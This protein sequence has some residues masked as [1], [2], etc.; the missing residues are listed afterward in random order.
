MAVLADVEDMDISAIA[1]QGLQRAEIRLENAATR[2]ASY[3]ADARDS[4]ALDVV[5]FA[6]VAV[7][8]TSARNQISFNL[9]ILSAANEI[10]KNM[11]NVMA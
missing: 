3:G 2:I 10:R 9:K 4:I 1:L 7:A 8:L 11:V 6:A 5:E